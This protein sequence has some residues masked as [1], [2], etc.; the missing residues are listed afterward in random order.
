MFPKRSRFC[1]SSSDCSVGPSQNHSY[2][3]C[4]RKFVPCVF[5]VRGQRQYWP[6]SLPLLSGVV[7]NPEF[8]RDW[9]ERMSVSGDRHP[10]YGLKG[11]FSPGPVTFDESLLK[12]PLGKAWPGFDLA[13]RHCI[14]CLS[15]RL[16]ARDPSFNYAPTF[17]TCSTLFLVCLFVVG[18]P[19]RA[20]WIVVGDISGCFSGLW[21]CF[22]HSLFTRLK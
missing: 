2:S 14:F 18:G 20:F 10:S 19:K 22:C 16:L 11:L 1:C 5:V 21:V 12:T 7:L 4:C 3:S 9:S 6:F 17:C 8:T 13:R 15:L